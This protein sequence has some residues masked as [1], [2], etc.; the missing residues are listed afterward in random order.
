MEH[1]SAGS[2]IPDEVKIAIAEL[3][4]ECLSIRTPFHLKIDLFVIPDALAQRVMEATGLDVFG[5][6][7]C[8]EYKIKV[9]K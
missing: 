4:E 8:I 9:S 7:V 5:H 3:F 1:L 6:W 2:L